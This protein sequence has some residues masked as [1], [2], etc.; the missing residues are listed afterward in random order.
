M[1]LVVETVAGR[2]PFLIIAAVGIV[3]AGILSVYT[4]FSTSFTLIKI[5]TLVWSC[6]FLGLGVAIMIGLIRTPA[7]SE[8]AL[9][10]AHAAFISTSP[11]IFIVAAVS[12]SVRDLRTKSRLIYWVIAGPA[13]TP[14]L[15]LSYD[16]TTGGGQQYI[17]SWI[18]GVRVLNT[19]LI[20]SP[21]VNA[22]IGAFGAIS[23]L[24]LI[25]EMRIWYFVFC[26]LC[27]A[28]YLFI[29]D[30]QGA[31][32]ATC[33]TTLF[34]IAP[35]YLS[36]AVMRTLVF[37]WVFSAPLQILI[38][39]SIS[40]TQF[41]DL[42]TRAEAESLGVGTG[43][44][45]IWTGVFE[46]IH[47]S[48]PSYFF[49]T[50][51]LSALNTTAVSAI[52]SILSS[53]DV[54]LI[55]QRTYSLH[56]SALQT[57]FDTGIVGL[58]LLVSCTLRASEASRRNHPR[59]NSLI[60]FILLAGFNEAA[61]TVYSTFTYIP[62]IALIGLQCVGRIDEVKTTTE[63]ASTDSRKLRFG[64]GNLNFTRSKQMRQHK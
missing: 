34:I 5:K 47:R 61:G 18:S 37:L 38:Y 8:S 23:S 55:L 15:M 9:L 16:L 54:G 40:G 39:S 1:A 27:G 17:L 33:I 25:L 14:A 21:N 2:G 41:G 36:V 42:L 10:S 57:L 26:G 52:G 35:R 20:S 50:G 51:Y 3:A 24:W 13:L 22:L 48:L 46:E 63:I 59:L 62:F 43:R 19:G 56:N 58:F 28:F 45:V 7:L 31:F 6:L 4:F 12:A 64:A 53:G 11:V 49:G 60:L 44:S 32:I 29:S 30:S